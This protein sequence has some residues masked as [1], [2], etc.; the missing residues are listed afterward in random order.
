MKQLA[1]VLAIAWVTGCTESEGEEGGGA[2]ASDLCV[3]GLRW[4]GGNAESP[5]MHPGSDC[6][7][8][9]AAGEGPRFVIAGTVHGSFTEPADCYGVPGVAVTITDATG[10][11]LNLMTND[12]GNFYSPAAM[13]MPIRATLQFE[14]RERTMVTRQPVGSCAT[15]HTETGTNNAPGRILAP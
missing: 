14:G 9:H 3:S 4:A 8:C 10:Q 12:A 11:T 13:T 15:C 7:G 5:S 1:L 6:I 2:V